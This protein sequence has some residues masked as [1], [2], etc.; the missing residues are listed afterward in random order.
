MRR[1]VS[2]GGGT[3]SLLPID[4]LAR[5]LDGLAAR[6]ALENAEITLEANPDDLTPELVADGA[7][8]ASIA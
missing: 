6:F 3:P 8:S 2:F 7:R 5:I 4:G 1:R